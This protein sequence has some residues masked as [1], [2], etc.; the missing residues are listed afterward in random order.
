M[1]SNIYREPFQ[2]QM[3]DMSYGMWKDIEKESGRQLYM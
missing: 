3:M 1:S 2:V